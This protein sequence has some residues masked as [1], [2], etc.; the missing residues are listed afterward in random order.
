MTDEL[1]LRR[2]V[3][4]GKT[5]PDDY[6]V[7]WDDLHIGR[8]FRTTAVG[9]G[10]DWSWSCFLPNVPQRSAHRGHAASLDAAKMAFRSAWAALQSDPQLRRDQAGARDRR[11]PQPSLA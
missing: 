2:A 8:I 7:I 6:V 4:G 3:I 9:G 11:R 1:S 5:A 10:A